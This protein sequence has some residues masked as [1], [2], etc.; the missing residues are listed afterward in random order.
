M[1][2]EQFLNLSV[3]ARNTLLT[4]LI[5]ME[6]AGKQPEACAAMRAHFDKH[7]ADAKEADA[8]F[9]SL[10]PSINPA[11]ASF[12]REKAPDLGRKMDAMLLDD[13]PQPDDLIP[14]ETYADRVHDT[15]SCYMA[16]GMSEAEAMDR[17]L[18][19]EPFRAN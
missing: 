6:K 7:L 3:A 4:N 16:D 2:Y 1:T 10:I 5:R 15:A 18:E 17:A 9:L 12:I 13:A 8:R 14:D 11:F 19:E